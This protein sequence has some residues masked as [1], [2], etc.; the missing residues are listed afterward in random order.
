MRKETKL[1]L[2][3][4]ATATLIGC[5]RLPQKYRP[6]RDNSNDYR[7]SLYTKPLTI[8]HGYSS[9]KFQDYYV[10]PNPGLGKAASKDGFLP[11]DLK[12]REIAYRQHWWEYLGLPSFDKDAKPI[13]IPYPGQTQAQA[14]AILDAK[15]AYEKKQQAKVLKAQSRPTPPKTVAKPTPVAKPKTN[16]KDYGLF[17]PN[18][19]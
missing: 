2:A 12:R 11:P 9:S 15:I 3:L 5:A 13:A 16:T 6:L 4:L 10:V 1:I 19:P 14:Q 18:K 8:P 17:D 7:Q